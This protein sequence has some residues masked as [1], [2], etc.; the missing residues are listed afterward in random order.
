MDAGIAFELVCVVT[1]SFSAE[2]DHVFYCERRRGA[3]VIVCRHPGRELA[4]L[5]AAFT[6]FVVLAMIW[7]GH[8]HAQSLGL[9]GGWNDYGEG[10]PGV[11]PQRRA[12]QSQDMRRQDMQPGARVYGYEQRPSFDDADRFPAIM[13][14]GPRPYITPIEPRRVSFAD[15]ESAGTIVIDTD[16]R[17]LYYV[18]GK[19]EAYEYPI[20]VGR[21]GFTW[22]GTETISRIAAWPDWY[23]PVEM[24]QRDRRLPEKMHGGIKNPLGAVAL[25]LGTS[26]Y[27]IH[28]T[29]DA[30]T[31]GMAASSGCFRMLNGH[32]VH[33]A[34]L[35][36]VGTMVKVLPHLEAE[37]VGET[38]PWLSAPAGAQAR[39]SVSRSRNR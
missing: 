3:H 14:G 11:K 27:R 4:Q 26:L 17:R 30:K 7:P 28:G 16:G 38:L 22:T 25:F 20:S 12:P 18:L 6:F 24:R 19:G 36:H 31:I 1:R 33:L 9:W 5:I 37:S 29:N 10:W 21:D 39:A 13:D 34:S 35:V 8:G 2:T 15:T 32:A 23:P